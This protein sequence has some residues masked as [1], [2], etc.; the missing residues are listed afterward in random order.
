MRFQMALLNRHLSYST[1]I[2]TG[3]VIFFN[4]VNIAVKPSFDIHIKPC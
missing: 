1:L 4:G 2:P 3:V